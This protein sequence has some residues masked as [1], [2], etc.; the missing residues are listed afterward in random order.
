MPR[1][2]ALQI[3]ANLYTQGQ[4]QK[5]LNKGFQLLEQF[6]NSINLYN[7]IG[8]ANNGLGKFDEA[9]KAY[10][11]VLSINPTMLKPTTT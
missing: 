9:I 2:E 7:I 6:P 4:Y 5:A 1:Q 11:K 3:L 8:A 10:A